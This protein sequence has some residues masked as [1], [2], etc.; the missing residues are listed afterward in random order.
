MI[1]THG[2]SRLEGFFEFFASGYICINKKFISISISRFHSP[3]LLPA[4]GPSYS[5]V[6]CQPCP[7][8]TSVFSFNPNIR[9]GPN[10]LQFPSSRFLDLQFPSSHG[11]YRKKMLDREYHHRCIIMLMRVVPIYSEHIPITLC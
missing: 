9:N 11:H 4:V 10:K 8:T 2:Y 1:E 5:K 3:S 6:T 7:L